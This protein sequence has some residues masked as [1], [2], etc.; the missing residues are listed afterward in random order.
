MH[1]L[2]E[3][4]G[5]SVL[6]CHGELSL[7]ELACLAAAAARMEAWVAASLRPVINATGVILHT[8]LGRA[9]L[10]AAAL[11]AML[12]VASSYST[13]EFDLE[14]G[15]RGSR[16]AHT[17]ALLCRLLGRLDDK[18]AEVL[19]YRFFDELTQEE[20]A[21]LLATSRKTVGKRLDRIRQ[22]VRELGGQTPDA[23][24]AA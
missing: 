22:A 24:G 15:S 7:A 19:V 3:H 11:Q 13:L 2:R 10:S 5:V 18:C 21:E 23:G 14:S 1:V 9:P 16:Q 17:E 6:R 4:P 8:N 12:E 20:I